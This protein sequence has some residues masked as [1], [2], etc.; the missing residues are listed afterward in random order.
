MPEELSSAEQRACER[1]LGEGQTVVFRSHSPGDKISRYSLK[2]VIGRGGMGVV[3]RALDEELGRDVALK[4]L[5]ESVVA[6][7]QAIKNLK[8]ETLKAQELR[9]HHIVQVYDFI[10]DKASPC[11]AMEYI[12]GPTLSAIKARKENDF[13]EVHEITRWVEQLCEALAYAH[14]KA[15]VVHRDLKPAN[16]M[17]NSKGE[18]KVTDFGIAR[19]V[20]DSMS[21]LSRVSETSGTLVYMS[22]QQLDGERATHLDD[23]YSLGATIYELLTGEPPFCRGNIDKQIREKT[24]MSMTARRVDRGI[25]NADPIPET[26]ENVV[27]ACLAK[28]PAQRPQSAGE[29]IESLG[30]EARP[31]RRTRG[32]ATSTSAPEAAVMI[33]NVL[34]RRRPITVT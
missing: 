34:Y 10:S 27:A 15:R 20:S 26:W 3:W 22:P 6:D 19:S 11:I 32:A 8:R 29:V 33:G 1:D 7:E 12:D 31:S 28:D 9:H 13:L 24:P 23:I 21:M 30:I 2:S 18:L 17:I 14:E 5:P 16:L 4:F 25:T